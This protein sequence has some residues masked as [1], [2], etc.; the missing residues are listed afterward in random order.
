MSRVRATW[1]WCASTTPTRSGRSSSAASTA[2]PA[3]PMGFAPWSASS[4]P[5]TRSTWTCSRSR[6]PEHLAQPIRAHRAKPLGLEP[7]E[8]LVAFHVGHHRAHVAAP[9]TPEERGE[10]PRLCVVRVD[11]ASVAALARPGA[12]ELVHVLQGASAQVVAL[13]GDDEV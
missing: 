13:L 6:R 8:E 12:H 4:A 7:C 5:R 9:S 10:R 3:R 2:P 11:L 1:W